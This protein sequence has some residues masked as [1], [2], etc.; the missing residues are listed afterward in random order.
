MIRQYLLSHPLTEGDWYGF[1]SPK[2]RHKTGIDSGTV[3]SFLQFSE[4]KGD[5]ALIPVVWDQLAYFQNPFEQGEFWHPGITALCQAIVDDLGLGIELRSTV[6]CS[7]NFTFCNYLIA[8]PGYWRHWLT[9]ANDIFALAENGAARSGSLASPTD[10]GREGMVR[11]MKAFVQERLPFLLL[12]SHRFRTTVLDVSS[13]CRI[14]DP[15]PPVRGL[16][17]TCDQLKASFV[18]SNQA[19]YLEA[20]RAVRRLIPMPP[21]V[22]SSPVPPSAR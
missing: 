6:A 14:S 13:T 19:K 2:F 8:K 9:L 15:R 1:L 11:P 16:L 22:H 20:Y 10:Y 21:P 7:A 3:S 17:Q 18:E 5:V 12:L 4:G